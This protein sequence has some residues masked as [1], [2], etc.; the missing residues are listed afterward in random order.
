MTQGWR[1]KASMSLSFMLKEATAEPPDLMISMAASMG[2]SFL[3]LA[4]A[5]RVLPVMLL[6]RGA[7]IRREIRAS[8]PREV[9]V[10]FTD[11]SGADLGIVE[12]LEERAVGFGPSRHES[13]CDAGS[14]GSVGVL[15][16]CYVD[17]FATGFVDDAR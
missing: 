11:E 8:S 12:V 3:S 15:A 17:A 1:M 5:A 2:V 9:L 6:S 10:H 14:G 4:I 16:C 7:V 13:R